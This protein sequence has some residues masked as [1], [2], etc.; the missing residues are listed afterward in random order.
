MEVTDRRLFLKYS[1][2]CVSTL[3]RRGLDKA[4]AEE[5]VCTV[6]G[7]GTIPEGCEKIFDDALMICESVAQKMG[8]TNIDEEVIRHYFLKIHPKFVDVSYRNGQRDFDPVMCK[9]YTGIVS[10]VDGTT[11]IVETALGEMEYRK[12]FAPN[13]KIGDEVVVHNNFVVEKLPQS[14]HLYSCLY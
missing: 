9:T 14:K 11:A 12:D 6:A 13:V 3:I 10:S 2:P 8:K 7:N 1:L 5:L 4:Y